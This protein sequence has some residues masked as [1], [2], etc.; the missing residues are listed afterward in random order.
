MR[1]LF[2]FFLG[3]ATAV[4]GLYFLTKKFPANAPIDTDNPSGDNAVPNVDHEKKN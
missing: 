4:G 3:I 1:S 2:F